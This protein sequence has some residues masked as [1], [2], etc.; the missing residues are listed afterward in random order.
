MDTAEGLRVCL[1]MSLV[2]NPA[3]KKASHCDV[4]HGLGDVEAVLV[5]AH[6]TPPAHEPSEG[7]LDH[8]TARQHLEA[9][10][11]ID[12]AH[13]LDDEIEE[14]GLVH[15]LAAVIGAVCEEM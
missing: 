1:R 14:G 9:G 12:A 5:V 8:P 7:A 13:D 6:E 4:D 10:L 11:L 3:E 15:E 2:A